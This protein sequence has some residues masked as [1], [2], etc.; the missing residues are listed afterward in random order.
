MTMNNRQQFIKQF[1]SEIADLD[2]T[3]LNF[4]GGDLKK[5]DDQS[6]IAILISTDHVSAID[7]VIRKF[8]S[9]ESTVLVSMSYMDQFAI[10]F[11]DGSKL[12]LDCM[13]KLIRRNMV[14]LSNDYLFKNTIVRS[15][16]KCCNNNSFFELMMIFHQLNNNGMPENYCQYFKSIPSA[17]KMVTAFN[18]KYHAGFTLENIGEHDPSFKAQLKN[19][20]HIMR[21]NAFAANMKNTFS[22]VKE[23]CTSVLRG[24]DII[25]PFERDS[26]IAS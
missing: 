15:G 4:I 5:I 2:Y 24:R 18:D 22:Y 13:S 23:K 14:Y 25:M 17:S 20:L 7:A 12:N 16:V 1:F 10:T 21:D 8:D 3:Y 11:K 9:L 6:H 19:Y 26:A